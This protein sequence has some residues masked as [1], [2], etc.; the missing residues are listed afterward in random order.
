[1]EIIKRNG[2]IEQYDKQKIAV[3][4]QKSFASTKKHIDDALIAK[5][6]AAVEEVIRADSSMRNVESIQDEVE[7]ALMQNGFYDEA[8]S[9]ILF[10][11][12]RTER[13]KAVNS[14]AELA[15]DEGLKAVLKTKPQ[16]PES[17][18]NTR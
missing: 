15:Q 9:Y 6:V 11:F 3:A 4:I 12:Q 5:M 14:I 7:K 2:N 8:K 18:L 16:F 1:M 17:R 10:R 13:R